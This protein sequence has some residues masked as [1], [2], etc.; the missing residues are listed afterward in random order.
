LD[1][2]ADIDATIFSRDTPLI[3]AITDKNV[4]NFLDIIYFLIDKTWA[5]TSL[6]NIK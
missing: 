5:F 1:N 4:E 6:D 3:M 2:G